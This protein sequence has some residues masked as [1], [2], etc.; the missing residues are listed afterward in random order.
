MHDLELALAHTDRIV[1]IRGGG[2]VLD[3]PSGELTPGDLA[4]IYKN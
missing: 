1:G 4:P 3:R 2:I